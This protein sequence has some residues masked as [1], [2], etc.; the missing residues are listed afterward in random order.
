VD[1]NEDA[2]IW[3]STDGTT[4]NREQSTERV[5]GGD[6]TQAV[7]T[8]AQ[9]DR[10]LVAVGTDATKTEQRAGVWTADAPPATS[11]SPSGSASPNGSAAP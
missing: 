8:I 5:L 2:A 11:P 4:W 9:D 1:G 6:G 10:S 3:Y 7:N